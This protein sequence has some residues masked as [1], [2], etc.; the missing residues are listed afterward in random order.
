MKQDKIKSWYL[1]QSYPVAVQNRITEC[2]ALLQNQPND[3]PCYIQQYG[4]PEVAG[5][6]ALIW[7]CCIGKFF[8]VDSTTSLHVA[9]SSYWESIAQY[10]Q[11][12]TDDPLDSTTENVVDH[13]L[14]PRAN[15]AWQQYFSNQRLKK[16]IHMDT[17]RT[18]PD[19]HLFRQL[20]PSMNRILFLFAK[21][22]PELGYIQ[23]MNE[24]VAPFVYVYLWDAMPCDSCWEFN[25]REAEAF[26]AFNCFFSSFL[27]PLYENVAHLQE[28]LQQAQQLLHRWDPQ[29]SDHLQRYQVDWQLFGTR[30]LKLCLCREF[31]LPELLKIWDVLLSIS[32]HSLRWKWLIGWMVR[33]MIHAR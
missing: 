10:Q 26:G 11:H 23:G 5:L 25:D 12:P 21:Q 4:I 6:R 14:N 1:S 32:V 18:H 20:E 15:S 19:W 27:S 3:I 17:V 8:A 30:W 24:L 16:T 9:S 29:L 13:P 2:L 33:M 31:E 28:K 22:H 7:N